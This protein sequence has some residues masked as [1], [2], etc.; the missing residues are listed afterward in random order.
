MNNNNNKEYVVF[1]GKAYI[2]VPEYLSTEILCFGCAFYLEKKHCCDRPDHFYFEACI[3]L[4][5]DE[6]CTKG[7]G[8]FKEVECLETII[9]YDRL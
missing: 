1:N 9:N 8:I 5:T 4:A 2:V 6:V 7:F 3:Q